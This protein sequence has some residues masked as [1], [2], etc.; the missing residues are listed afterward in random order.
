[1]TIKEQFKLLTI[2][3]ERENLDYAVIGAFALY[4][5]GYTRTTKDVDFIT[6]IEYQKRI[7]EYLE[8]LGFKTL[9]CSEGFSNH[10]HPLGGI[11]VDLVY[12]SGETA[13]IIFEATKK[14]LILEN[15]ELPVVNLEHLIA[16]KLFAIQNEPGRKYKELADIKEIFQI[17]NLDRD[18]IQVLFKKYKMEEYYNEITGKNT[19]D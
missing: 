10:L 2:F 7:I 6:R 9:N 14:K 19:R 16:M 4:A 15:L 18:T 8:S 13:N 12:V 1:M 3:F 5:Y 17:T 11:R